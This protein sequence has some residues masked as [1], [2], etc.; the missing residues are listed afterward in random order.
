MCELCGPADEPSIPVSLTAA[1]NSVGSAPAGRPTVGRRA[2]LTGLGGLAAAGLAACGNGS[3]SAAPSGSARPTA[4]RSAGPVA[5]AKLAVAL[6]GT[7]AGPLPTPD[8]AGIATALVV[9]GATYIVDCGRSA[10]TQFVR[11]GLRLGSVRA[12]FLTHL[13]AD[14]VADFYTFFLMG[15]QPVIGLPGP[16]PVYGPGP[17]GGLPTAYGGAQVPTVEP[18]SP[19]PGTKEMTDRLTEA[20]AYSDN[21]FLRDTTTRDVADLSVV[22][23]IAL[24]AVGATYLN[25][26][27]VTSP[28]EVMEDDRVKVTATLVPHGPVFPAFAYR[29]DTAHGSVTFSGDTRETDNLITLARDTDLLIHEAVNVQGSVLQG[30]NLEHML[31]SH[32]EVQKVGPIAQR[33]GAKQLVLSHIADFANDPLDP[34]Q[35]QQWAKAGYDGPV[36]IGAD[37]QTIT[38]A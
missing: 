37:L 19:T 33:A 21:V 27:P 26:A 24:P 2:V 28:F 11:S 29:F 7:Q 5:D 12:I 8:R 36:T 34:A 9:D 14:H 4:R 31:A 1:S 38:L 23:E 20:F 13:H 17:A 32:V 35:W 3:G 25:T 30:A 15:S 16:I 6:L 18:Q 10:V 22:H